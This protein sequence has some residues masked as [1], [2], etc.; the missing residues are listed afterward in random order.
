MYSGYGDKPDIGRLG[1]SSETLAVDKSVPVRA[2][3][4]Q[5]AP[6][7]REVRNASITRPSSTGAL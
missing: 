2:Q 3:R 7:A 1:D 4:P 6:S 5:L